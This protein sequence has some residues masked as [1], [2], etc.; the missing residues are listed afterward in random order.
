MYLRLIFIV[1]AGLNV[2]GYECQAGP[3]NK[4]FEADVVVYGGT[5][6]GIIAAMQILNYC[7]N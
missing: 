6:S 7:K 1:F 5:S 3:E 4:I 2:I